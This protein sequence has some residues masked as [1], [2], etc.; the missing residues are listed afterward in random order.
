MKKAESTEK[1]L[2]R[3]QMMMERYGILCREAFGAEKDV[4]WI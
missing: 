4:R 3:C 2:A 1:G